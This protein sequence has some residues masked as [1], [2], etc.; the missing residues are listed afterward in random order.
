MVMLQEVMLNLFL[1][2]FGPGAL[3]ALV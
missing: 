1:D 3:D 2:V